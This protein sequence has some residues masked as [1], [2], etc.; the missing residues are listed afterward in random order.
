MIKL[1]LMKTK[2]TFLLVMFITTMTFA[3]N[4]INYKAVIK[5]NLGNVV[6]NDL[7]QVQFRILEG[8]AQTDVY[9]E[10]HSPTTDANGVVILNIG[11]GALLSGSPAF[12]TVDWANDI[13]YLEVSVNIGNGLQNLGITE[14]KTVPY[15]ITSGDKFWDKDSNHV[16]VL[17][18]NIGI[19]TNSPS[20]RLAINDL[21]N[22]GISL[23]VP[24]LSNTS[25]IEFRNGLETGAHTFYKIEN[26]SDNLRFEIDSDLNSTSG[27]QNKMTLNYSGLSLE[28]GTRINE[29][30][31]DGTLSGNSHN[32]VPTEQAVKEY[33]D[34][35]TPVLFK[36]RGSG[37]AVKDIDGGTEVETDIWAVEVYDTANSFNTITDRFVAPS[38]GY[39]F[40]H[41][42]IRQSNFVTPAYFRIRFNV[43][44]ASQYTTIVDGD[45]VKTE[46]SGIYYLSAGQQVYV[47]LRNYSVGED[48]RMD[49][50]GSWFEG[51]KL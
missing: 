46:V 48:E 15:A 41:A 49:G 28:N 45:T 9:S 34:N 31:T 11:E 39:Y 35:K 42:V 30:S 8:L 32:A 22:A 19:G 6:A 44:T 20:E 17:S 47:L 4:G 18:E 12:S 24:L 23:E 16:Y 14:F 21:N 43:D 37:F 40:L 51:Y 5:D 29:F 38:S 25:K 10:T 3:Q 1:K 13:H 50:S 33:V 26:R 36:V 27:F 7:I 2:F